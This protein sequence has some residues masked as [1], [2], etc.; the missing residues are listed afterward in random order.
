MLDTHRGFAVYAQTISS[1]ADETLL[2]LTPS[3]KGN[4]EAGELEIEGGRGGRRKGRREKEGG[5]LKLKK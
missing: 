5:T 1:I 3:R 4:L 2:I